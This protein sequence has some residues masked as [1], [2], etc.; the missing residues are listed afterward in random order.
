MNLFEYKDL[1][2]D[3]PMHIATANSDNNPNLSDAS[4]AGVLED[5][6]MKR[7]VVIGMSGG[8]DSSVAAILLQNEGYEV[9]GITFVFTEDFD[10]KDAINVCDKIGIEHHII[11]YRKEFK[12][13]V[14]DSFLSDYKKGITPNPCV[15]CNRYVKLNFLYEQMI[16]YNCDYMATGH[17][18]KVIDGKLYKSADENKDQT[19]FLCEMTKEEL[20]HIIFPLEGIDKEMVR[21]I[22]K[23][24]NLNN[25]LK[26]DSTDVCF[27]NN[28]FKEYI[29]NNIKDNRGDVI[30]VST[31][32]KVGCHNG[33]FRYTIGQRRGL[34]IG[35]NSDRMF[36]VGKDLDKNILYV[37]V[38]SETDYLISTSCVLEKT[39]WF[40]DE[41]NYDGLTAKF[42]Y[43]QKELPVDIEFLEGDKILVK[44]K[45][46]IK[47]VTPGQVCAIY[48]GDRCL[49]GG[50]IKEVQKNGKKLWYL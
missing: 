45:D 36:V 38:G 39:N 19:Y 8:V 24:N 12:E 27:I 31:N 22:A 6:I 46:G 21:K 17:Y 48:N 33:L 15:M 47:S 50:V 41:K 34:N 25:A 3:K 18:A 2:N 5:D 28:N 4:D 32:K 13:K 11:D 35:G 30:D 26:K 16:K 14:I 1:I 43:R 20:S 10:A 42:R 23:E 44:Y 49:G 37:I 9:I 7:K 40:S 29:T